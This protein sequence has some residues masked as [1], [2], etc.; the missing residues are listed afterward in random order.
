MECSN[1]LADSLQTFAE[2]KIPEQ[3]MSARNYKSSAQTPLFESDGYLRKKFV[4]NC[5]ESICFT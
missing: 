2:D 1:L 5:K 3:M 4:V